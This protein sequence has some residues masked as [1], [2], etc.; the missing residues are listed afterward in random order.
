MNPRNLIA[1]GMTMFLATAACSA[2]GFA[3]AA[4]GALGHSDAPVQIKAVVSH[5][6]VSPGQTF[7]VAL[8][9]TIDKEYGYYSP[10]P[11]GDEKVQVLPAD[12]SVS[13]DAPLGVLETLWPMDR[14]HKTVLANQSYVNNAYENRAI[15]YVP[16]QVSPQARLGEKPTIRFTLAGQTCGHEQCILV[17]VNAAVGVTIAPQPKD[18]P[19]WRADPGIA[20][21]LA[22]AMPAAELAKHHDKVA[23]PVQQGTTATK[24]G[25]RI[26]VVDGR[27]AA[28][29]VWGGLAMALLAGVML[30]IMPCVLPVIPL[31]VLSLVAAA[32]E[33]RRRFVTLGLAFA[34]GI[35]VFFAVLA[36]ANIIIRL[37]TQGAFNWGEH[38]QSNGLRIA[39]ALLVTAM[40]ANL[41]GLFSVLVP[42]RIAAMSDGGAGRGE[43]HLSA[44][45][46]GMF[47]AV[48]STPCSFAILTLA[49]AWAQ[50]QPLWLGTLA[51]LTIG[52]GMAGPY[53]LLS[54]FPG[55]I[56]RLPR[57]GKW[58]ELFKQSMG[59]VLLIVAIWL[60][61]TLSQQTYPFWVA[62]YAVVL[63]YCLW[64][65]GSWVRYDASVGA[66]LGIRVPAV[67]LALAAG[68]WM[69]PTPKP[70]AVEFTPFN[71]SEI[72]IARSQGRIVLI[73][74][75]AS[76]CLTCKTVEEL[77]YNDSEVAGEIKARNILAVRG[78]ITTRD[79]PANKMLYD[80]L[81]EPGVPVTVLFLPGRETPIRLHGIF[82][83]Q[84]LLGVLREVPKR[85]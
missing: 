84:D 79:L 76:W 3:D 75:T 85:P 57:P 8:D 30:N 39:M 37:T 68:L 1:A 5:T 43:T 31:K 25:G 6:E 77:V 59:F 80:E 21:G 55:L 40:A 28:L 46:A 58:M 53:A 63:V 71:A 47:T 70:P 48:L 15:I 27:I 44:A 78:D 72:V 14:P 83:K 67:I 29:S 52:A 60:L 7:H 17:N 73:D 69:L 45:G 61:A 54:A 19:A 11:R 35:M 10:D 64:M 26:P 20:S 24:A 33:S 18:N 38:F 50:L 36:G 41:F 51:I 42:N 4:G 32:G 34:G 65:W 49:F 66:K 13:A 9:V 56:S 81:K 22:S 23:S 82:R 74:F 16:V 12:L 2:L 62:A